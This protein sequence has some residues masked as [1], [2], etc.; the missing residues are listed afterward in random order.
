MPT[1]NCE[2]ILLRDACQLVHFLSHILFCFLLFA[3][4][5]LTRLSIPSLMDTCMC[6]YYLLRVQPYVSW[7]WRGSID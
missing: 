1:D 2:T 3:D 4:Q 5:F 7:M 6:L